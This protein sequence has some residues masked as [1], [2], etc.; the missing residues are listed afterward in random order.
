MSVTRPSKLYCFN[1]WV[2]PGEEASLGR[3]RLSSPID[4]GVEGLETGSRERIVTIHFRVQTPCCARTAKCLPSLSPVDCVSC[5]VYWLSLVLIR[6][7]YSLFNASCLSLYTARGTLVTIV[8]V[9]RRTPCLCVG[10]LLF[11]VSLLLC[12]FCEK[13]VIVCCFL[14]TFLQ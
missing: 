3:D 6:P 12:S 13:L 8:R 10:L 5:S 9:S 14:C 2:W 4:I 7:K 1:R 11:F